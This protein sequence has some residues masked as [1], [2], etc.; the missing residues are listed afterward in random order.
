MLV[1]ATVGGCGGDDETTVTLDEDVVG[2]PQLRF[3][4]AADGE[5]AFNADEAVAKSGNVSFV[6]EN[7]TPK[8]HTIAVENKKGK[9]L[10]RTRTAIRGKEYVIINLKPGTYTYFCAV[11]GHR[12]AGMEGTVTVEQR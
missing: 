3:E 9:V 7:P 8:P 12:E 6:I 11:P 2:S 5:L 4:P 10:G 1:A